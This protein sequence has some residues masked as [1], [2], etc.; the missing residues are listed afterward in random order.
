MKLQFP[1]H[2]V[3]KNM[4]MCG[5]TSLVFSRIRCILLPFG[6]HDGTRLN[7]PAEL[8][9]VRSV[10]GRTEPLK[11]NLRPAASVCWRQAFLF[12]TES[13]VSRHYY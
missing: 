4:K 3:H 9:G 5:M 2:R 7:A 11:M 6:F 13:A 10:R 12:S 8:R 1:G